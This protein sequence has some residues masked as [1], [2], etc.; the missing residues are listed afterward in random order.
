MDILEV[1]R[2][3]DEKIKLLE[4]GRSKLNELAE[5]KARSISEYDKA[6]AMSILET[7]ETQPA[8]LCEKV[9]KGVVFQKRYDMEVADALYRNATSKMESIKAELNGLQSINRHLSE[10]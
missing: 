6:L 5:N 1:A 7:K 4:T 9:A 10:V 8:T 3:I 2:R